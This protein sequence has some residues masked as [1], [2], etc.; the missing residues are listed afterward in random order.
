MAYAVRQKI[1]NILRADSLESEYFERLCLLE[2]ADEADAIESGR[3]ITSLEVASRTAP[4][5]V[6]SILSAAKMYYNF[7]KGAE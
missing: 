5:G 7:L 4:H 3:R 1:R 6:D 2:D